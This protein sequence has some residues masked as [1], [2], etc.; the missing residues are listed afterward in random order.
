MKI[1]KCVR[2]HSNDG[3]Y[4]MKGSPRLV[5]RGQRKGLEHRWKTARFPSSAAIEEM[6]PPSENQIEGTIDIDQDEQSF[7]TS[8]KK[9]K[10]PSHA[11]RS[12]PKSGSKIDMKDRKKTYKK[13]KR[14]VAKEVSSALKDRSV[15]ILSS[16]LK[17]RGT[18]KSWAKFWCVVK[19]GWLVIYKSNKHHHW[20]GTVVLACC[21]AIER[22]SS[23][24]GYC[25]KLFHPLKESIWSTKGPKGEIA[26]SLAQPMP[27]DHLILRAPTIS[28]G[29]CWMDAI[30]VAQKSSFIN[31]EK[32]MISDLYGGKDGS[33]L[34]NDDEHDEDAFAAEKSDD[35]SSIDDNDHSDKAEN[36]ELFSHA[37]EMEPHEESEYSVATIEYLG[38]E[39]EAV[40]EMEEDNKSI[41]WAL[42]KQVRPGMDLSK[43]TLPT[44]ILEPR[45]FLDK[46]SDYYYHADYLAK[47]A[48]EED[49][50]IR[51]KEVVKW[52]L[53]GFYKKPKGLKKPYNPIIGETF[54]CMWPNQGNGSK[55]FFIA[56]Q[57]S[58]HPPV[59]A[60]YCSNRKDGYVTY[61]SILAKSK[62][63]GNSSSA[64]LDGT[65]TVTLLRLGEDYV[66]NMPYAHIKGILLGTLTAEMGG[67]V[68]IKCEK[69]GYSAE[70][71]FKLKPFWNK[72]A[73][74]NKISGKIKMSKDVLSKIEGKWDAEI[75]ITEYS[76]RDSQDDEPL[77]EIFFDPV[78]AKKD[79]LKRF[80]VDAKNQE[81]FE[82]EKLWAKVT[83][84]IKT[85][86]QESATREKLV[87]ED[88]QRALHKELKE[89]AEDWKPRF[90]ERDPL[91]DSPHTWIYKYNDLRPWDQ[92]TD[93]SQ[94]E[95]KCIIK[96]VNRHVAPVFKRCASIPNV[97][98]STL[99]PSVS[100]RLPSIV[101]PRRDDFVPK[102]D[103]S[104]QGD[105]D[106]SSHE[107]LPGSSE[108]DS[109]TRSHLHVSTDT[110]L[111]VEEQIKPLIHSQQEVQRHL[112][113]LRMDMSRLKDYQMAS[114]GLALKDWFAIV[115]LLI[116]HILALSYIN[117]RR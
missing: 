79:R 117:N 80:T 69:T 63:Y 47:A 58:H 57:V 15:V 74:S 95:H 76:Q 67:K 71:E 113:A 7:S 48:C 36:E 108:D 30:E 23:K 68:V 96:T 77:A 94:Y 45:S 81:D 103:I 32:V 83:E 105:L 29:H 106:R 2:S 53:S 87:L 16:W 93:L 35:V 101:E 31:P 6:E 114:G 8:S 109:D 38:E 46:L 37:V 33:E 111:S 99:R 72:S 59:S 112:S 41:L 34:G 107:N 51:I 13:E 64:I 49:P 19:P 26:G 102:R 40:E 82:S 10:S 89:K 115:S 97:K 44:F 84:A 1:F 25:F 18:L 17:I 98:S 90:F 50:Y 73:Q 4:Y 66:V 86:D 11:E 55:T 27:R 9:A 42:L 12:Q 21:E 24:E 116:L 110:H 75:F 56:E 22:P 62:F 39:G 65:A 85:Q 43:V 61:G 14:R 3:L 104:C 54:R 5:C 92:G 70:I 60:F 20:V 78:E 52:Y 28:M 88:N 100:N 91:A